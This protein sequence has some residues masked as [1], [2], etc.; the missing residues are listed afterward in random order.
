VV[1]YYV[2]VNNEAHEVELV[3]RSGRIE[4][5][6]DGKAVDARYEE[7]DRLG[8]VSL[9]L[10]ETCYA[11]SLEGNSENVQVTV[12]G[13]LYEVEIEDE[14]ERAAH[15][16]EG[17]RSQSSGDVKSVMPGVVV[18]LL[19]SE[20]ESV[21]QGQPLLILEAMKMQ[22]EIGAPAT[23]VVKQIHVKKGQAVAGGAKLLSLS[24]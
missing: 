12:A 8:Q 1:K 9:F 4:L 18:E 17:S 23:G 2:K 5:S 21:E 16:A 3:E 13:R 6:Y 7:V 22:N 14:R 10:G 19:V 24:T 20:G 11:V 15:Q